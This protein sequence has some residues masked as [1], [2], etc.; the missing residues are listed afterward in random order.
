MMSVN[1]FVITVLS[2]CFT[3]DTEAAKTM[4][5]N[6]IWRRVGDNV[7]LPCSYTPRS[8]QNGYLDIEW[9]VRNN[10]DSYKV[11][12]TLSGGKVY[13]TSGWEQRIS[14]AS[15]NGSAGD[16]SLYFKSLDVNDSGIYHCKVKIKGKI[17]QTA[18]NLTVRAQDDQ[19]IVTATVTQHT[20][21]AQRTMEGNITSS[22]N[23]SL[24]TDTPSV[25]ELFF[26]GSRVGI[27]FGILG[28]IILLI[29]SARFLHHKTHSSQTSMNS[30]QQS[31]DCEAQGHLTAQIPDVN[32]VYSAVQSAR[33]NTVNP[34]AQAHDQDIVYS[35]VQ[36]LNAVRN[37]NGIIPRTP[38]QNLNAAPLSDTVIHSNPDIVYAKLKS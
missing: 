19:N 29:L 36:T 14:F 35:K 2:L 4:N 22:K 30:V 13:V 17:R 6:P 34:T 5:R 24:N 18:C 12:L 11:I 33:P 28:F 21:T 1:Y 26:Y 27:A 25:D 31:E 38:K 37:Y 15:A 20:A 9:A 8:N 23:A 32:I 3:A 7:T 10:N 16:A